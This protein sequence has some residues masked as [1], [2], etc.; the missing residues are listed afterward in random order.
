MHPA[1]K[2][3]RFFRMLTELWKHKF[4]KGI[5]GEISKGALRRAWCE[6][7]TDAAWIAAA[8]RDEALKAALDNAR[9]R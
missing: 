8:E 1:E 7:I 6:G 5:D 9:K 2:D 3:P 4:L